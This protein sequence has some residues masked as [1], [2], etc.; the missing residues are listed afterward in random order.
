[1]P[2]TGRILCITDKNC[3]QL[4]GHKY[5]FIY[6]LYKKKLYTN[7][8]VHKKV[9]L[10]RIAEISNFTKITGQQIQGQNRGRSQQILTLKEPVLTFWAANNCAKHHQ[11][12]IRIVP[13]GTLRDTD[14]CQWFYN[15]SCAMLQQY[16]IRSFQLK[17]GIPLNCAVQNIVVP[18]VW[19]TLC[20]SPKVRT[21]HS[22][23]ALHIFPGWILFN[24]S[25]PL[26]TK[27]F[28]TVQQNLYLL[29]DYYTTGQKSCVHKFYI[30]QLP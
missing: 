12:W 15:L 11:N 13:L 27:I 10:S 1:V 5:T 14:R 7:A 29:I 25:F 2:L 18:H 22:V 9:S 6:N 23:N 3:K 21:L 8:E 30:L 4:Y 28:C 19:N 17:T 20:F 26:V 16:I 24:Y